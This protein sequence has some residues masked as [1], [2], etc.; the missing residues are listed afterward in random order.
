MFY[1][2]YALNIDLHRWVHSTAS[3]RDEI[4]GLCLYQQ[5]RFL[6]VVLKLREQ[7]YH[8]VCK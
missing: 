7:F 6:V 5:V 4:M 2:E 1:P 3:L 8:S